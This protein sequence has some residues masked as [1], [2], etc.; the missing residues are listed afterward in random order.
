VRHD[1]RIF[2]APDAVE[3]A[4]KAAA[5]A[6]A[7][8][9]CE[10]LASSISHDDDSQPASAALE[11]RVPPAALDAFLAKVSGLGSVGQHST[12]SEDKTDE[13]IDTEARQK[14]MAEFRD[15]LRRMMATSEC[16][17]EGP[18]RGRARVDAGSDR[19]RQPRDA[20]QG[21]GESD[22]EGPCEPLVQRQA[23]G[24]RGRHLGAAETGAAACR[25]CAGQQRR[26]A[27]RVRGRRAAVADRSAW[28]IAALR[29]LWRRKR[30]SRAAP[31]PMPD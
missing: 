15:N 2:T 19:A 1:L 31:R 14:N 23:F 20:A 3:A 4:W 7:E 9:G 13:V 5:K 12:T 18:D 6:C 16:E 22:R 10:L 24:A 26:D 29:A 17:A 27:D 8:A 25:P 28:D 21:A 30:L 11:A